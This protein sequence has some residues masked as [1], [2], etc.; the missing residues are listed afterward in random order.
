[1]AGLLGSTPHLRDRALREQDRDYGGAREAA[2][3]LGSGTA[4]TA[5]SAPLEVLCVG[6]GGGS[7]PLFLAH[8]FP[9]MHVTVLELDPVVLRAARQA[10][11]LSTVPCVA[12]T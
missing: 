3:P 10:C 9:G 5:G 2:G 12:R 11:G 8:H 7:L 1:M 4:G 6:L